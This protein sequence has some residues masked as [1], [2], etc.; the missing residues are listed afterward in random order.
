L[1]ILIV[2]HPDSCSSQSLV[3]HSGKL[4]LERLPARFRP[5]KSPG[6]IASRIIRPAA[7]IKHYQ[8]APA[9]DFLP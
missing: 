2:V 4:P 8:P 3:P 5:K 6:F 1:S 7:E 9:Y